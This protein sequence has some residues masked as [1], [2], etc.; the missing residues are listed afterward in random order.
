MSST[1][2]IRYEP[3]PHDEVGRLWFNVKTSQFEGTAFFWSNLSEMAE[4]IDRFGEYPLTEKVTE[5][6]GFDDAQGEDVVLS[7]ALMPS[8][9]TGGIEVTV[10]VADQFDLD[11]RLTTKLKT[12]Y[13]KLQELLRDLKAMS[14]H[15]AG[16]ALLTGT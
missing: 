9:P 8:G 2:L 14:E 3:D 6:W 15:R 11:Q 13:S 16:E 7:L 1:L 5:M 12:D 10:V 4:L